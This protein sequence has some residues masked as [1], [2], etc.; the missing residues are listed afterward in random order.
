MSTARKAT[1]LDL[2]SIVTLHKIAFTG[3]FLTMLGGAFLRELYRGFITEPDGICWIAESELAE[4]KLEMVGFVAG[5]LSPRR[6]FRR[7]LFKRGFQ[8][9]LA[10]LPGVARHPLNVVPRVLSALWYRGD[11][12]NAAPEGALLSSLGVNPRAGR[13]GVGKMLVSAFCEDASVLGAP[14][15]YLTTDRDDNET[16]NTFYRQLGFH[17][18]ATT[19][20][21]GRAMNTYLRAVDSKTHHDQ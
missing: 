16:V 7:L 9:A 1:L 6:F 14:A 5:T 18:V 13:R 15:V 12:P 21:R 17:I 20:R 8:F 3:F 2:P 4:E 10:A 11:R 19:L